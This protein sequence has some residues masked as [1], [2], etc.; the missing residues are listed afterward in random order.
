[1]TKGLVVS[2][3][4]AWGLSL[5]SPASSAGAPEVVLPDLRSAYLSR[6]PIEL[7]VAGL[8][9]GQATAIE[10]VPA[11]PAGR[12]AGAAAGE[13]PRGRAV[14]VPYPAG[15][16]AVVLPPY[17][18]APGK[19]TLLVE[20]QQGGGVPLTVATGVLNSQMLVS[21][22]GGDVPGIHG[23]FAVGS[24]VEWTLL[25]PQ[26]RPDR[27]PRGRRS[28]GFQMYEQAVEQ[29]L[30]VLCYFYYTGY[31]L[32]KPWGTEKSWAAP[33][34]MRDMRL[35][36]FQHAQRLRRF[37]DNVLSVGT[38][39]EPGLSWGRTPAGGSASGFP[40]WDERQW[41]ERHGW[42]YTQDVAAQG[43]ADWMRYVRTRCNII[44][45]NQAQAA[46]DLKAAWPAAKFATD[47][48][49]LHAIMD[50]TD[51]LNQ[52]VNDVP[53]THVFFD[54][55]GGPMAVPGQ[56]YLEKAAR[57]AAHVAHAMNGQL[58]APASAPEPLYHF[59]M[60]AMLSAG[61]DSNW[62]LNASREGQAPV[63][64]RATRMGSIFKQVSPSKHDT[65]VL[66]S[67]SEMAMRQKPVAKMESERTEGRQP[68]L[69]L[70][71]PEGSETPQAE[72]P[73]SA[74][75]VG[76][77]YAEQVFGTH[78]ALRRAGYAAH[79]LDE[80]L[81]HEQL[82][83]YKTLVVVGQTHELLPE[84]R[85]A[86]EQFAAGGGKV[87]ADKTTTVELPAG[88]IVH[89]ADLSA[90][91]FRR[92]GFLLQQAMKKEQ[93]GRTDKE[94]MTRRE[95]EYNANLQS[96]KVQRDAVAGLKA[97]MARTD[98][99]PVIRTDATDLTPER[100]VGGEGMLYMVLNGH[101]EFPKEFSEGEPYPRYN[102]APYRATYTLAGVPQ[103]STVYKIERTDWRSVT[104]LADPQ[105]S[106]DEQFAAGEMK[107]YLVAPRA[108]EGFDAE[109]AA[110]QPGVLNVTAS[111]RG[112]KM[113]WPIKV[114][115]SDPTGR[116][117]YAVY[118]SFDAGGRYAEPFPIGRNAP[119]GAYAIKIESQAGD[120]SVEARAGV[121][122]KDPAPE[123]V[124]GAVRV[125]D[126]EAIEKFLAARPDVV[127]VAANDGQK[128]AAQKL[129]DALSGKGI[130]AAVKGESEAIRKATYPRVWNPYATLVEAAGEE[131]Q[132][133]GPVKFNIEAGVGGVLEP[134]VKGGDPAQP[135]QWQV[136]E[137]VVTVTGDGLLLW[138]QDR[139]V[140]YEPGV[141]LYVGT[142]RQV[143][144]LKGTATEV[145]TTEEFRRRW[146][147]PWS[148]LQI[149]V[150]AFQLPPALPE[151]YTADSHLIVLGDSDAG[152]AA[153]A[154]QGSDVLRQ[155]VD[156]KY[157][158]PGR[159]LVQLV[160]SP[161]ALEK[162][163]IF[164]GA[165]DEA[166]LNAGV[167]ALAGLAK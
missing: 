39:D 118:R 148:R 90:E 41:Y 52:R 6:E 13:P 33:D 58:T 62:W 155:V 97:A 157:P 106:Q 44:A 104:K 37:A 54:F 112:V 7:A 121:V 158:G 152:E 126:R 94:K 68:S 20:G 12:A 140:A 74:Y 55:F 29:D 51:T 129:A 50:G 75:E 9:E 57:P 131:K 60:N 154:L 123:L 61:L 161:F 56:L 72:V 14:R 130:K 71:L 132:P 100:H 87:V 73:T 28:R 8:E 165:V 45:E 141:K 77:T 144:V 159:A 23:N 135:D 5:A 116:P 156:A 83:G 105:A 120:L 167:E 24:S 42:T 98:S 15:A 145:Q 38:I 142:D 88:T 128:A 36:N 115:V 138:Q 1:M 59:L 21:N 32:H 82:K 11:A 85:R 91:A 93:A 134:L 124:A 101:E 30:P 122:A 43:D 127:I 31:V 49:A 40:N 119:A 22:M 63:N 84:A 113:P 149:F 111:L 79:I 150:G 89:D 78:E 66:W 80:R 103:G 108:P 95:S 65:A 34:M 86:V 81:L 18:L 114:T 27:E 146:S 139:E 92:H 125:L 70:P 76:E 153:A 162:N 64:E 151:A 166:G 99:V 48:Y 67:F 110:D 133:A 35:F 102:L 4:L 107:L 96:N 26:G 17:A 147:R 163:V 136:P 19:Y 16:T 47:L 137:S 109:A 160:W 143:T 117:L 25:D 2:A 3:A 46:R 69:L 10:V 53:T 164:I